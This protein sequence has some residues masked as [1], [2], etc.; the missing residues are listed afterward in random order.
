M[1]KSC[2][3]LIEEYNIAASIIP[4]K[5]RDKIYGGLTITKE[6]CGDMVPEVQTAMNLW[7]SIQ[8]ILNSMPNYAHMLQ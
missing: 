8:K 6:E 5:I 7:N 2:K 1:E 4:E 3:Q